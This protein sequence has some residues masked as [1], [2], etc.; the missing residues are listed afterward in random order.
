MSHTPDE[1]PVKDQLPLKDEKEE[2]KNLSVKQRVIDH[3]EMMA[4]ADTDKQRCM[5]LEGVVLLGIP[6]VEGEE[7]RS[8]MVSELYGGSDDMGA[9]P[10]NEDDRLNRHVDHYGEGI[11]NEAIDNAD[12]RSD[13]PEQAKVFVKVLRELVDKKLLKWE[14]LSEED[15]ALARITQAIE[16][17]APEPEKKPEVKQ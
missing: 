3:L 7:K 11:P 10:I 12:A 14:E 9:D 5:Q 1:K 6:F 15:A 8:Q 4:N 17:M 16:R 13:K 2:P